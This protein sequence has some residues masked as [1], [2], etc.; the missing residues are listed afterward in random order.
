MLLEI[1][2]LLDAMESDCPTN[3]RRELADFTANT[4]EELAGVGITATPTEIL[5]DVGM[6][7]ELGALGDCLDAFVYYVTLRQGGG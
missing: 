7:T 1:A 5:R 3:T 4:L 6:S 2:S